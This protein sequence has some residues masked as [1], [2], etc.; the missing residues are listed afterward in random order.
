MYMLHNI[1]TLHARSPLS[2]PYHQLE[3]KHDLFYSSRQ[4]RTNM[5]ALTSMVAT[6][7]Q[8]GL[9]NT[10]GV[11]GHRKGVTANLAGPQHL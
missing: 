2:L 8:K 7:L 3:H 10:K 1:Y 6:L 4:L 5:F 11:Q 9:E